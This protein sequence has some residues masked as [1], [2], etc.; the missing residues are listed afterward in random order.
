MQGW[1]S[2]ASASAEGA[3]AH[4]S[5]TEA[6]SFLQWALPRLGLRW[7]GFRNVRGT[8]RKRLVRRMA[9]LG[10]RTLGEYRAR[11]ELAPDEWSKLDA[12]CRIPIS[13][14]YRDRA[15][16]DVLAR[17]V[18][19]ARARAAQREGRTSVRIWSAGCASGEEP[20]TLAIV[21]HLEVAPE[22]PGLSLDLIATDAD[23]TMIARAERR[24]YE[25]GSL[26][27]LPERLRRSAFLHDGTLRVRDELTQGVQFRREDMRVVMPDGPF[28]VILC[29]NVAFTYFDERTQCA[30]AAALVA[31]LRSGGAL[32]VGC[33]ESLPADF[34]ELR[35]PWP[36]V[37]E[38]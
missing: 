34:E 4:A 10:L 33:H 24:V 9:E 21:W 29:R 26:R 13:R 22:H 7:P 38:R 32:V 36:S 2:H 27:E 14:F 35:R 16:F 17:E 19:P 25:E 31:R 3:G 28:D 1:R 23:E 20:Y 15:V 6:V 5:D 37:Y 8:V 30:V 18:L 12:M 11:L